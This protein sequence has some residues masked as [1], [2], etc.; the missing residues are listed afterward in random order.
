MTPTPTPT[1]TPTATP[2]PTPTPTG[3]ACVTATLAEHKAAGRAISYGVNPY[4]PYY[5]VG[6]QDYLGQGDATVASLSP[7][8]ATVWRK[9]TG[10]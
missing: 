2:T 7:S 4:N 9:V 3:A 5:A 6:S 8:S 10:C 1:A